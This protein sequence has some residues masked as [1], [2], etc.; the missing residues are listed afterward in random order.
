[1]RW[2]ENSPR[3]GR[4]SKNHSLKRVLLRVRSKA[5]RIGD[6][7]D[8]DATGQDMEG[9]RDRLE[10]EQVILKIHSGDASTGKQEPSLSM[11]DMRSL[12]SMR[13]LQTITHIPMMLIHQRPLVRFIIQSTT[14]LCMSQDELLMVDI[15]EQPMDTQRDM[16]TATEQ[17]LIL[18]DTEED[19]LATMTNLVYTVTT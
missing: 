12:T 16:P 13:S 5:R 8:T 1:M 7:Q 6:A 2:S 4:D 14:V 15:E 3:E 11:I 9:T 19:M 17:H 18:A 10:I